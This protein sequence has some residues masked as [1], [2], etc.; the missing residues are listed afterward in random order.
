MA[1]SL[2]DILGLS[3]FENQLKRGNQMKQQAKL[4]FVGL[5]ALLLAGLWPTTARAQQKMEV[6]EKP[7]M[8]SYV[9]EWEVARD[10]F[11]EIENQLGKNSAPM[12]K[13]LSD[14]A[15]VGFGT[16]VNLV[17]KE[18]E[19]THDIWWSS[20][21]WASLMKVDLTLRNSNADAPVLATGKHFDRI[22]AARYYNWRSG[23]FTNGYTRVGIWKLKTDA[24]DNAV[25]QLSKSLYVPMFEK[26]LAD[27]SIYEYEI[28][29]EAIHTGDPSIFVIVV[30]ANG[31]EGLDKLTAALGESLKGAPFALPAFGSWVDYAAHRDGLDLTTGTYK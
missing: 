17:H 6:K 10:K 27:G 8:Y 19:S 18:G 13:M 30:I 25:D 22:Y 23:S 15:I 7:P 4:I 28:D 14:G 20:M 5:G 26:L 12:E 2:Y 31:P 3:A 11:K 1:I 24:P 9:A 16:D 29:E 21:S